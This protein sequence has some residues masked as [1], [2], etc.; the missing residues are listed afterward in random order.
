MC[1]PT[2]YE[3]SQ[4]HPTDV[5]TVSDAEAVGACAHLLDEHRVLVE[6]ACGAALALL[7]ADR[8]RALFERHESV[9]VVVCGG[10]GVNWEIMEQWK[11][12]G[13]W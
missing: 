5:C 8:H 4:S 7:R 9:V 13:L 10:S 1:S 3:Y 6:P 12:D 2:T 11:R